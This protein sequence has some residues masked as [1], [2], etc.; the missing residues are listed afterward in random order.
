MVV[1]HDSDLKNRCSPSRF[2]EIAKLIIFHCT[3]VVRN[4]R[5]AKICFKTSR[6]YVEHSAKLTR[7]E[8]ELMLD[9][10]SVHALLCSYLTCAYK[11]CGACRVAGGGEFCV[12][13]NTARASASKT[14]CAQIGQNQGRT[15]I[16]GFRRDTDRQTDRQTVSQT[17]RQ[18]DSRRQ[19]DIGIVVHAGYSDHCKATNPAN[20]VISAMKRS[21]LSSAFAIVSCTKLV[22]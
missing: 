13:G 16:R 11:V 18:S 21:T 2:R 9:L 15:E 1:D 6:G 22:V 4:M 3:E 10:F 17:D 19:T 7:R 20:R 8:H 14:L 12:G 5:A